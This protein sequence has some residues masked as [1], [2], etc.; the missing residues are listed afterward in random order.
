M[1]DESQGLS[2]HYAGAVIFGSQTKRA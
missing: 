1:Q 2:V